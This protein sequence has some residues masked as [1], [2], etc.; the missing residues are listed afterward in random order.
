MNI[1]VKPIAKATSLWDVMLLITRIWLG[2]Q[3]I[4]NGRFFY[5]MFSSKPDR[6]FFENWFGK[7]LHFPFPL[8]M[9]F[10]AK[11]GEFF[12][13]ILVLTGLFTRVGAFLIAFTMLVATLTANLGKNWEVDGTITVSFCLF[14]IPLIYWGGGKYALDSVFNKKA[15]SRNI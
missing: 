13:G 4:H 8:F 2:Y 11:G 5:E 7:G 1:I 15:I 12:G 14:A 3:M 6:D 10:L 9:A